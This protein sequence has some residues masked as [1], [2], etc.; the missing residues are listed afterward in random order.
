MDSY[1]LIYRTPW[2][3][4]RKGIRSVKDKRR[5]AAGGD[6]S[7]AF[8]VLNSSVLF[9]II[10]TSIIG[11]MVWYGILGFNVLEELDSTGLPRLL[12]EFLLCQNRPHM[13]PEQ[14]Y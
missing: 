8:R 7:G 12:K 5:S 10:D 4:V 13:G 2:L 6:V 1:M 9:Y 14:I 11:R 3:G